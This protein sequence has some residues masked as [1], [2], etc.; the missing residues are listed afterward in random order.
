MFFIALK[1]LFGD[2]IKFATLVVGLSFSVLLISQQA[3]IFSGLLKRFIT[4]VTNAQVSIW[5]ADPAIKY[6]DDVK[7]LPETDLARVRSIPGVAWAV[8]YV[9]RL[10]QVMLASG[11]SENVYLI[12][13]D[14][15]SMVGL[16][17]KVIAG[18]LDDL[19]SPDAIVIDK[20]G[21]KKL[22]YPKVGTTLEINDHRA[23]VVA[24]VDVLNG[25]QSFPYVYT[26]YD[27]AK[28][29]LPPQRKTLSYI[30]ASPTTGITEA[31]LATR[32]QQ[33]TGLGAYTEAQFVQKTLDYFLKNTGIPINFGITVLLGVAV[34]A[35]VSAQ[36]FYTFVVE[37]IRQFA[38]LKAMG[39][40]NVTLLQMLL[41]QSATAG[42]IGYGIGLGLMA[43]FG[44][45]VPGNSELSFYTHPIIPLIALVAVVG[46]CMFSSV[47]SVWRVWRVDPA[48]VFKG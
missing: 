48:I 38:T 8:P 45:V 22:G 36:T 40:H 17:Q 43:W 23:R 32:I 46:V 15:E 7:P 39:T 33:Q 29:F 1:M 13:I 37:N 30:F 35:A 5:V 16:P 42:F 19:N 41:L 9:Q 14:A 12:G 11:Q 18:R 31:Q 10:T 25:F 4:N 27:R 26:T 44:M 3:S 21:L 2:R 24:I 47:F 6:V 28:M 34:G 20:R